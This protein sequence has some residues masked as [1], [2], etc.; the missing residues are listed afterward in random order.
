MALNLSTLPPQ[1]QITSLYVGYF[2]RAAAPS[3]LNYWVGELTSGNMTI[4]E[5]A[6]SFGDQPETAEL[7]PLL[8]APNLADEQ[9]YLD[10]VT[11]IFNNLLGREPLGGVNNYYVEQ[12]VGGA[13]I[14]QIIVDIISGA[15]GADKTLLENKIDVGLDWTAGAL[16]NN[17]GTK[18]NPLSEVVDGQLNILDQDAYDSSRGVLDGVTED[19]ATVVLAKAE[20]DAFFSGVD[21]DGQTFRLTANTDEGSD[22]EGTENDDLYDAGI[23]QFPGGVTN[24][25]SSADD[26]DGKGGTDTLDAM[27]LPE[28]I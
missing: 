19:P 7:Y 22:F 17:V 20:T 14:G 13:D 5:I 16:D 2:D 24:A 27:L 12:L 26:L 6:T 23:T 8:D 21:L 3:G 4:T 1:E 15:Q 11:D 9:G 10:L 18:T 25:L 28:S